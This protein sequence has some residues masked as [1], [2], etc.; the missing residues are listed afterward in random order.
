VVG[1]KRLHDHV[2]V[3]GVTR[4]VRCDLPLAWPAPV[5][6][7][8]DVDAGNLATLVKAGMV[9]DIEG[10]HLEGFGVGAVGDG[11]FEFGDWG[12]GSWLGGEDEGGEQGC[13]DGEGIEL[14]LDCV[15]VRDLG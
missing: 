11:V 5:L 15:F 2:A 8:A 13:H 12:F 6:S 9:G 14:H 3:G 4:T 10:L 1:T 7:L